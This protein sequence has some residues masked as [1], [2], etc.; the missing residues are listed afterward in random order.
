MAASGKIRRRRATFLTILLVLLA[1][2][3]VYSTEPLAVF[4]VLEFLTPQLVYRI[5][6]DRPR[7]RGPLPSPVGVRPRR[8]DVTE[9][10]HGVF[11]RTVTTEISGGTKKRTG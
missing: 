6:M 4:P 3:L 11:A 8:R 5:K 10:A 2:L 1:G 7:R 9:I